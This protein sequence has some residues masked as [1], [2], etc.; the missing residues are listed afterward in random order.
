MN[1]NV[2]IADVERLFHVVGQALKRWFAE[3]GDGGSPFGRR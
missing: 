2:R 3:F 1:C